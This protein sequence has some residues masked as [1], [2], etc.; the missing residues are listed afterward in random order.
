ME[1]EEAAM[2]M[3]I[4][5]KRFRSTWSIGIYI[6]LYVLLYVVHMVVLIAVEFTIIFSVQNDSKEI[7]KNEK[8]FFLD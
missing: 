5:V 1:S 6:L 7:Y 3:M 2:A 4:V 8:G